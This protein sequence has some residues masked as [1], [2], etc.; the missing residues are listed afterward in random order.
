[1]VKQV[2][3]LIKDHIK[4]FMRSKLNLRDKLK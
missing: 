1:M 3:V 2:T 4:S